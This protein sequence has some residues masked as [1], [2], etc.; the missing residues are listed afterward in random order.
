MYHMGIANML[1][2]SAVSFFYYNPIMTFQLIGMV[3]PFS[4]LPSA[5]PDF[6]FNL[7]RDIFRSDHYNFW[8]YNGTYSQQQGLKAVFLTDTGIGKHFSTNTHV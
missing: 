8:N 1:M 3:V 2:S 7:I 4:G 6:I 5:L